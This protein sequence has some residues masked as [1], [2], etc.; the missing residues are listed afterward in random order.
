MKC[1]RINW[2]SH[3]LTYP[4][5]LSITTAGVLAILSCSEMRPTACQTASYTFLA[6]G[7]LAQDLGAEG[8][9]L[10]ISRIFGSEIGDRRAGGVTQV[11]GIGANRGCCVPRA[12]ARDFVMIERHGGGGGGGVATQGK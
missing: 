1:T 5:P 2:A 9:D 8:T 12:S 11:L 7:L 10:W 6:R 4:V 3:I